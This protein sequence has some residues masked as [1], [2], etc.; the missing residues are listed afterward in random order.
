MK[1]ALKIDENKRI[2]RRVPITQ[3][4]DP[5]Y[6]PEPEDR[7]PAAFR[8]FHTKDKDVAATIASVGHSVAQFDPA[9]KEA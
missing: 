2:P 3:I 4:L 9:L 8:A 6:N 5:D 1:Y 7:T